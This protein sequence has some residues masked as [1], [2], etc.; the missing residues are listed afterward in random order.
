MREKRSGTKT[1]AR[2]KNPR[3]RKAASGARQSRTDWARVDATTDAQIAAQVRREPDEIEFTDAMLAEARWV[4][5]ERKIPISFRVDPEVLAF[6]KADG[7]GYQSRMNAVLRG[8][9]RAQPRK[10]RS[11]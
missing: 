6:F 3:G 5:P 8:Y 9:V 11:K 2:R 7:Q 4:L 1:P 10:R